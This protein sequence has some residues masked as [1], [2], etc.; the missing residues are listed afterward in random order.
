MLNPEKALEAVLAIEPNIQGLR[1][2][3]H[4]ALSQQ[5]AINLVDLE[6]ARKYAEHV[7]LLADMFL[8]ATD[9]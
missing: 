5:R 1:A 2:N 8:E 3:A 9:I 4:T 6:A 7:R